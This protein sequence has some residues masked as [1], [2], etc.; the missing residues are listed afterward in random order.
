MAKLASIWKMS[1]PVIF[2]ENIE[3]IDKIHATIPKPC[4]RVKT[5][6]SYKAFVI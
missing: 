6:L 1:T 3:I 2:L 4:A 5:N